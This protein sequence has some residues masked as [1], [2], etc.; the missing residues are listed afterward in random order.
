MKGT[1]SLSWGTW[2]GFYLYRPRGKRPS[3]CR[4]CIGWVA[5]TYIGGI[6]IDDLMEAY[7][8]APL[9]SGEAA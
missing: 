2:G 7:A 8:D 3:I 9:D 5:I 6:E 1:L 4:L